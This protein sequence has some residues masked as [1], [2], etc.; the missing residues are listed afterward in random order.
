MGMVKRERQAQMTYDPER[1]LLETEYIDGQIGALFLQAMSRR[2]G[3]C[4]LLAVSLCL[5]STCASAAEG[6][7]APPPLA[8]ANSVSSFRLKPG[9]RIQVVASEPMVSAPVAIAFDENGRLFVV[10]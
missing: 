6:S 4:V 1:L 7:N 9:F 5:S 2:L 10:E 8:R 3:R